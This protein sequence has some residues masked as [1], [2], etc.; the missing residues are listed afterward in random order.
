MDKRRKESVDFDREMVLFYENYA[1]NR[2]VPA[3]ESFLNL[4]SIVELD[5]KASETSVIRGEMVKHIT[6]KVVHL[7][8][9]MIESMRKNSDN[10]L[11][12][13][14]YLHYSL[15]LNCYD[16][17]YVIWKKLL[18]SQVEQFCNRN[19]L[20][21]LKKAK[22]NESNFVK[23]YVNRQIHISYLNKICTKCCDHIEM[24][25]A[26]SVIDKQELYTIVVDIAAEYIEKVMEI[27]ATDARIENWEKK[28]TKDAFESEESIQTMDLVLD[29][30]SVLLQMLVQYLQYT[31]G[32]HAAQ[33]KL[34]Q[35]VCNILLYNEDLYIARWQSDNILIWYWRDITLI[36][37]FERVLKL[38]SPL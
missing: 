34:T 22:Q 29:E 30:I 6:S 26:S 36:K 37:R 35:M 25:E 19:C 32:F 15:T 31:D 27:Y 7:K 5:A 13:Y 14:D 38:Q 33:T 20:L 18:S 4:K 16:E 28:T 2:I 24:I 21:E 1:E 23:G 10:A 11:V 9:S 12:A 8:D 17:M 3:M